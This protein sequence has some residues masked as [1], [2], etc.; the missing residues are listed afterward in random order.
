MQKVRTLEQKN[1]MSGMS[2]ATI[3][4]QTSAD[5]SMAARTKRSFNIER[6]GKFNET[7]NETTLED[8]GRL[9]L[10][11]QEILSKPQITLKQA[12]KINTKSNEK[13]E[14]MERLWALIEEGK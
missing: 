9:K 7:L 1:A 10:P 4:G 8:V 6:Q 2:N 12:Q 14:N 11:Q 5:V 3:S 13:A